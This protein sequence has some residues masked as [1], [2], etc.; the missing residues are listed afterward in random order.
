MSAE[1]SSL[2]QP[3]GSVALVVVLLDGTWSQCMMLVTEGSGAAVLDVHRQVVVQRREPLLE[4]RV[5]VAVVGDDLEAGL[6]ARSG[7]RAWV[8]SR[9]LLPVL[10]VHRIVG[11][12]PSLAQKPSAPFGPSRRR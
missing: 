7:I 1:A 12:A 8:S 4:Q 11:T 5:G 6:V 3:V 2:H 9:R 10:I